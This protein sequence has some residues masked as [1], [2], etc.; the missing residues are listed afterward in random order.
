VK[1]SSEAPEPRTYAVSLD[2]LEAS[3][4]VPI[5][6]QVSEQD[7]SPVPAGDVVGR[8]TEQDVVLRYPC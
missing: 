3:A 6:E 7:A 8:P 1:S 2:V 4:R 5:A